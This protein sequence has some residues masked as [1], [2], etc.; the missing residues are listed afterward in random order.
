LIPQQ[1]SDE[2]TAFNMA[3][4]SLMRLNNL[5]VMCNAYSVSGNLLDKKRTL[6]VVYAEIH[7]KLKPDEVKKIEE[8]MPMIN[9]AEKIFGKINSEDINYHRKI[10]RPYTNFCGLLFQLELLLRDLADKKGLLIPSRND[11]NYAIYR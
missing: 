10:S 4:A 6:S 9:K 2:L 11:P 8:L 7:P 1:P 3:V 5:F